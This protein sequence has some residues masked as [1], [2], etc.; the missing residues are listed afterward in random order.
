MVDFGAWL[1]TQS[2][3]PESDPD[4]IY[5]LYLIGCCTVLMRHLITQWCA[6]LV[7]LLMFYF[8][9]SAQRQ[10]Q[11]FVYCKTCKL[12]TPGKLRVRCSTCREG[13]M[14]L[15]Q[16]GPHKTA[17]YIIYLVKNI[18]IEL[19]LRIKSECSMLLLKIVLNFPKCTLSSISGG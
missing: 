13:A 15:Q 18:N 3:L 9:A 17:V 11:Y 14:V 16:V 12:V 8:Q 6:N 7:L 10:A 19:V 4:L 2:T 5:S 1:A